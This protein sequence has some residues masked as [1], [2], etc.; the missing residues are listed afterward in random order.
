MIKVC[1]ECKEE[2]IFKINIDQDPFYH[3]GVRLR[4]C[5]NCGRYEAGDK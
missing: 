1:D 2:S 3:N 5:V 4:E